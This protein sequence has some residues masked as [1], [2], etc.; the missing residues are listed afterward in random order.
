MSEHE[1][2]EAEDCQICCDHDPDPSEGYHCTL[3]SLDCSEIVASKAEF[4]S[5]SSES[6]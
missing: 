1:P 5:D 3:C 4:Y 2:C 6:R